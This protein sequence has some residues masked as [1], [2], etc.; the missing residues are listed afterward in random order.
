MSQA[1]EV[2]FIGRKALK[3]PKQG[4]RSGFKVIFL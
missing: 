3:K 4:K 2:S 1:E